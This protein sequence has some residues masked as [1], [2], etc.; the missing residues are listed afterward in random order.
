MVNL[1]KNTRVPT[2]NIL[3]AFEED[4]V[5]YLLNGNVTFSQ[6]KASIDY[7]N[8][9]SLSPQAYL[10]G[11]GPTGNVLEFIHEYNFTEQSSRDGI[12]MP[13]FKLKIID[14]K[15]IFESV[16][17]KGISRGYNKE[18]LL[19]F[20]Q[21]KQQQAQQ[22]ERNAIVQDILDKLADKTYHFNADKTIISQTVK[23]GPIDES[24]GFQQQERYG[25][26]GGGDGMFTGSPN[27]EEEYEITR[28]PSIIKQ[29]LDHNIIKAKIGNQLK[30]CYIA[31]GV[32]SNFAEWAGPFVATFIGADYT[33]QEDGSRVLILEF[34]SN[35]GNALGTPKGIPEIEF[36]E[37]NQGEFELYSKLPFTPSDSV[38][39]ASKALDNVQNSLTEVNTQALEIQAK[40]DQINIDIINFNGK[41]AS[42]NADLA[43]NATGFQN[44]KEAFLDMTFSAYEQSFDAG[45]VYL[46]TFMYETPEL[47]GS[48][49][50]G[51]L[52]AKKA[53]TVFQD[54]VFLPM[55]GILE[56]IEGQAYKKLIDAKNSFIGSLNGTN[57]DGSIL[58]ITKSKITKDLEAKQL[59]LKKYQS[60]Q[61]E[62]VLVPNDNYLQLT[63]NNDANKIQEFHL[64][65][66]EKKAFNPTKQEPLKYVNFVD[67][68]FLIWECVTSYLNT[69]LRGKRRTLFIIPSV[70]QVIP[71]YIN[72][73]R[74][75]VAMRYSK[76]L[77]SNLELPGNGIEI[78]NGQLIGTEPLDVS[79]PF[80]KYSIDVQHLITLATYIVILNDLGFQITY[81]RKNQVG[82]INPFSW[83]TT[84]RNS[85]QHGTENNKDSTLQE[86]V[87]GVLAAFFNKEIDTD[88]TPYV[89]MKK[90]RNK[91]AFQPV[92]DFFTN[93]NNF[94]IKQYKPMWTFE[95]NYNYIKFFEHLFGS[96]KIVDGL[97]EQNNR[98]IDTRGNQSG[99]EILVVGD[100]ELAYQ[101]FYFPENRQAR[102]NIHEYLSN[103][104]K[105]AV[106]ANFPV[107][108]PWKSI[109]ANLDVPNELPSLTIG[110]TFGDIYHIPDEYAIDDKNKLDTL[111]KVA[112]IPIFAYGTSNPN[113]IRFDFD[114]RDFYTRAL[115]SVQSIAPLR[116]FVNLIDEEEL[117]KYLNPK[118]NYLKNL[119]VEQLKLMVERIINSRR[120]SGTPTNT[121]NGNTNTSLEKEQ[122]SLDLLKLLNLANENVEDLSDTIA[123]L[124]LVLADINDK[125]LPIKFGEIFTNNSLDAQIMEIIRVVSNNIVKGT[126]YT[127]PNY[128][129]SNI[130]NA[131]NADCVFIN[132]EPRIISTEIDRKNVDSILTGHYKI[133]GFRHEISNSK[134]QSAFHVMKRI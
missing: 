107:G 118:E 57:K 123:L 36:A 85:V 130:A 10:L 47:S 4:A 37:Q 1:I 111:S 105:N 11:A 33:Y 38:F 74:R 68:D 83:L 8:N 106:D 16:F 80:E 124:T 60:A 102:K 12:K 87:D 84:N 50:T 13:Y 78:P 19:A 82:L 45:L 91:Y 7:L 6:L 34:M 96:D 77:Q 133:F 120:T 100:F 63:L 52:F 20:L 17:I 76:K 5:K 58:N 70:Y 61:E 51:D 97:Y 92:L 56:S 121:E 109:L 21:A 103:L 116:G 134:S 43:S 128:K 64:I 73:V 14:P 35:H 117:L 55:T 131:T 62:Q 3:F 30:S 79:I 2:S 98:I 69:F 42:I 94:G 119:T 110:G 99:T 29:V 88:E 95:N 44:T 104:S 101:Y 28:D 53:L 65:T 18:E 72:R 32:G 129:I 15:N 126:I 71:D 93:L 23:K 9:K 41:L 127:L 89:S 54:T 26:I 122:S 27:Q 39:K 22:K 49:A 112:N 59:E 24:G 132:K 114:L 81:K 108:E 40:I 125:E 115:R 90:P 25:T 75:E 48:F 66:N 31:Y 46:H 67:L 86:N 113:V